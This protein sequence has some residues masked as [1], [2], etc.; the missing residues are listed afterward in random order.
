MASNGEQPKQFEL[1][2]T[3]LQPIELLQMES[4]AQADGSGRSTPRP[5]TVATDSLRLCF[6]PLSTP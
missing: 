2:Q 6:W 1:D 5:D 3:E 4:F